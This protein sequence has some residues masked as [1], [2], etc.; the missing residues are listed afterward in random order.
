MPTNKTP[1]LV[2]PSRR[3]NRRTAIKGVAALAAA[4]GG[5]PFT[6]LSFGQDAPEELSEGGTL[7][8]AIVGEPPTVVDA[9]F[10]TATVTNNVAAQ[11]FEGLFTF[12][13]TFNPQPMLIEDY[14]AA[15]DGLSYTFKLRSGITFD[16]GAK[17]TSADVVASL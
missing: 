4:G 16:D 3:L 14:E 6:R 17:M 13:S 8:A 2:S 12:D 15:A 11:M 9:M 5:L 10:S 7:K 1:E